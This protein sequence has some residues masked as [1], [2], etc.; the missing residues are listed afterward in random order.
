MSGEGG[1]VDASVVW[2]WTSGHV[3]DDEND[4][5]NSDKN[6]KNAWFSK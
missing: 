4:Y 1:V 5:D 6:H 3:D 2:G